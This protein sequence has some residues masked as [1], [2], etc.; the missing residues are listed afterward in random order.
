MS[1]YAGTAV[2]IGY[3]PMTRLTAGGTLPLTSL[4]VEDA[5]AFP[6]TGS[7]TIGAQ[8]ITYTGK[9][10]TTFTGCTG[11]TGAVAAG[12]SVVGATFTDLSCYTKEY[13]DETKVEEIE[14]TAYCDGNNKSYVPGQKEMTLKF[15]ALHDNGPFATS[16]QAVIE[17]LTG[18]ECLWR[19]RERGTGTGKPERTAQG[20]ITSRAA[21]APMDDA[22]STEIEIRVNN[23]ANGAYAAQA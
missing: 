6:A 17:G 11:G 16:P 18:V 4:S 8:T 14:A 20:F 19:I 9:T 2:Q 7:L 1:K 5:S 10:G 23:I 15:V 13:E 12:A 3:A 21:S 22:V